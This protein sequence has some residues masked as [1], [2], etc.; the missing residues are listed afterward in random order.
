MQNNLYLHLGR[1]KYINIEKSNFN[2]H[3]QLQTWFD[4]R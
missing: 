4:K 1:C 2:G 3:V